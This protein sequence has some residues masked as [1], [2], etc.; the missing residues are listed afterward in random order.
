MLFFPWGCLGHFPLA[1]TETQG[2]QGLAVPRPLHWWLVIL[3]HSTILMPKAIFTLWGP[4]QTLVFF[5]RLEKSS[6]FEADVIGPALPPA[7][8]DICWAPGGTSDVGTS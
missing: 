3:A 2:P 8:P 5:N 7:T 1:W 4:F 6:T